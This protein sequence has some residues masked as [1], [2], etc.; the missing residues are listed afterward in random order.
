MSGIDVEPVDGAIRIHVRVGDKT[1]ALR[2]TK[3]YAVELGKRLWKAAGKSDEQAD[4][5]ARAQD[6]ASMLG[7]VIKKNGGP[8]GGGW[9]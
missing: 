8:F 9:P 5:E 4:R 6:I 7:R 3:E 2:V 1:A